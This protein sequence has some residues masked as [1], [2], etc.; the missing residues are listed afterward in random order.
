MKRRVLASGLTLALMLFALACLPGCQK[1]SIPDDP[2]RKAAK[3]A[4]DIAGAVKAMTDLKHKLADQ[5]QITREE[6]LALTKALLKV[7]STDK[8]LVEKLKALRAAASEGDKTQTCALFR[9]VLSAVGELNDKGVLGV[10]NAEARS[11]LTTILNTIN[12]L[13]PVIAN[14]LHC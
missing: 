4:D 11:R 5:K 2:Q 8:V 13:T 7:N 10:N 1:T 9:E 14:F 6:D 3:A 12:G